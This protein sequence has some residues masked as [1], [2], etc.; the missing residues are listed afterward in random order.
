MSFINENRVNSSYQFVNNTHNSHFIWFFF[1]SFFHKIGAEIEVIQ[2]LTPCLTK[3][4]IKIQIKKN[5]K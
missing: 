1:F 3:F 4:G 5:I 2:R